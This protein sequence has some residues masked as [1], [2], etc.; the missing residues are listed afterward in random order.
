M[1]RYDLNTIIVA[2]SKYSIVIVT[3][4]AMCGRVCSCSSIYYIACMLL[5]LAQNLAMP[6]VTVLL[7]T[8]EGAHKHC[9][10]QSSAYGLLSIEAV[11]KILEVFFVVVEDDAGNDS[12]AVS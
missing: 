3:I 10:A 2:R 1:I 9:K 12:K 4:V 7:E 8:S 5:A 6:T 11:K